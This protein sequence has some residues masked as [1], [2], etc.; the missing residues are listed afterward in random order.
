MEGSVQ[1]NSSGRRLARLERCSSP[2]AARVDTDSSSKKHK[3]KSTEGLEEEAMPQKLK[4]HLK[5][6]LLE[7]DFESWTP[8]LMPALGPRPCIISN[9]DVLMAVSQNVLSRQNLSLVSF[10]LPYLT[11]V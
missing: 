11:V 8:A 3:Q 5:R 9:T 2:N 7:L 6:C 1:L 10:L 4:G